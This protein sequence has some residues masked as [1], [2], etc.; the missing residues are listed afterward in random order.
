MFFEVCL[1]LY[2]FVYKLLTDSRA[3]AG[4][5]EREGWKLG[6]PG[7]TREQESDCPVGVDSPTCISRSLLAATPKTPSNTWLSHAFTAPLT[8]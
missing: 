6:G 4:P 3:P 1:A 2:R 8:P 7:S 5:G